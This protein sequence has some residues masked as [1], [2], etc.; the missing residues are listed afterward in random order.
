VNARTV[1]VRENVRDSTGTRNFKYVTGDEVIY[2]I[3]YDFDLSAIGEGHTVA[4]V[5]YQT[6]LQSLEERL[7]S[8]FG[9]LTQL[10]YD[11][12]KDV[13]AKRI[14]DFL[15]AN[16]DLPEPMHSSFSVFLEEI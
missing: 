5:D 10:E 16:P 13:F 8:I 1:S 3:A 12:H 7:A 15:A 6:R 4:R 11:L 9:N 14:R 2:P